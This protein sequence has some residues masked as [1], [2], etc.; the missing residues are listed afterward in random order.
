MNQT[1][2]LK[3]QQNRE[4]VKDGY[5]NEFYDRQQRLCMLWTI[6]GKPPKELVLGELPE[7]T[8]RIKL[9]SQED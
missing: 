4:R 3:A 1:E 2:L 7:A 8:E 5:C 6:G 9:D